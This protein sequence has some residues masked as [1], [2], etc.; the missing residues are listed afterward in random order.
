M[1][2]LT[3]PEDGRRY[4]L[5]DGELR[6]MTLGG[7]EHGRIASAI[8]WRVGPFVSEH[9][10]GATFAAE[11]GFLIAQNPD[12]VLAPDFAFVCQR[13]L[14]EVG[15]VSGYWPGAPDLLAEV[16]SPGDSWSNVE[17]KALK[18]LA[19]GSKVVWV[20]DPQQRHVTVYRSAR[21]IS[22]LG[23]DTELSEPELLPG[24]SIPVAALFPE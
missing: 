3:M 10:L 15:K 17:A 7:N 2:L 22:V 14:D 24:W 16:V 12:T 9:R 23:A 4:E 20:V 18:W 1:Q 19:C 5:I 13:R 6:T 21:N 11:T 8:D